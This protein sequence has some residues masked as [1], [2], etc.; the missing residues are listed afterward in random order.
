[1]TY[2]KSDGPFGMLPKRT[3][4]EFESASGLFILPPRNENEPSGHR[5]PERP[6]AR[7]TEDRA[8]TGDRI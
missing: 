2:R 3:S 5:G 6:E 4:M 8:E 7:P 1:M